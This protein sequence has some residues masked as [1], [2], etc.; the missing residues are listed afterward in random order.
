MCLHD[1]VQRLQIR[2]VANMAQLIDPVEAY[3][4]LFSAASGL[5]MQEP[6]ASDL[7]RTMERVVLQVPFYRLECL[8]DVSAAAL[9]ASTVMDGLK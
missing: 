6:M 9:C 1:A 3:A 2:D 5:K 4:A 7:H 8:P